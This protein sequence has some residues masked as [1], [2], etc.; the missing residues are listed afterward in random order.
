MVRPQLVV[1]RGVGLDRFATRLHQQRE[2]FAQRGVPPPADEGF[3]HG[4]ADR[5]RV[6]PGQPQ[7]AVRTDFDREPD[8]GVPVV[9]R[10][11]QRVTPAGYRFR[12]AARQVRPV[13][14]GRHG[15]RSGR[16]PR[17]AETHQSAGDDRH[18]TRHM[19]RL[20]DEW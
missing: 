2:R 12:V 16:L 9:Q 10:V 17:R 1:E 7:P 18:A 19:Y 6:V 8:A 15:Q 4:V 14:A 5:R 20:Q 3:E 11:A 13:A